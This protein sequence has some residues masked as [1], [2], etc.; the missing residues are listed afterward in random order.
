MALLYVFFVMGNMN[1]GLYNEN[2]QNSPAAQQERQDFLDYRQQTRDAL[3]KANP[4]QGDLFAKLTDKE[5]EQYQ[6]MTAAKRVQLLKNQSDKF[7]ESLSAAEQNAVKYITMIKDNKVDHAGDLKYILEN[8]STLRR[9][10]TITLCSGKNDTN[11]AKSKLAQ[12]Q[13]T[14]DALDYIDSLND[15][16]SPVNAESK[17]IPKGTEKK[18]KKDAQENIIRKTKA[19]FLNMV[20]QSLPAFNAEK[21]VGE[22][23]K[24]SR[25]TFLTSEGTASQ[26]KWKKFYN[27]II[28]FFTIKINPL[29]QNKVERT[30]QDMEPSD[31]VKALTENKGKVLFDSATNE[32]SSY[33]SK[34]TAIEK[35]GSNFEVEIAFGDTPFTSD[36]QEE[37]FNAANEVVH[38]NFPKAPN[39]VFDDFV[40][41]DSEESTA[42]SG[43][44]NNNGK[45]AP[46]SPMP[47]DTDGSTDADAD[48]FAKEEDIINGGN[49]ASPKDT[50]KTVPKTTDSVNVTTQKT[51]PVEITTPPKTVRVGNQ[52]IVLSKNPKLRAEQLKRA[53]DAAK[54]AEL[55]AQQK[56]EAPVAT[57][58]YGK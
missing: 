36:K 57:E 48:A 43:Q 29:R 32:V 9:E 18:S 50:V 46:V 5:V 15:I 44:D 1:G 27:K 41:Y 24:A 58:T 31:A 4:G 28:D 22:N 13:K 53:D 30:Q 39:F 45:E 6:S 42:V 2:D 10:A 14:L 52:D 40:G 54:A 20:E 21:A 16:S 56:V 7:Y 17:K 37:L 51:Q 19:V 47:N 26:S 34:N 25:I 12:A 8:M 11:A 55:R 3:N 38:S 49:N 33:N 35:G 23:L